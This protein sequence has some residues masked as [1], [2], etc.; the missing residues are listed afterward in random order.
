MICTTAITPAQAGFPLA[1]QV[2]RRR[3]EAAGR[4]AE[5]V[6]LLTSLPPGDLSATRWL[7]RNRQH[8]GMENGLHAR[9]DVSWRDAQG[10]LAPPQR[11][12]GA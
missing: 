3:R 7:E 5:T 9:L 8:W 2:A 4:A 10:R 6:A 12:V 1:A 11:R